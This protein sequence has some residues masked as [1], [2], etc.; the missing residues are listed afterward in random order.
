MKMYYVLILLK[1]EIVKLRIKMASN[2][3]VSVK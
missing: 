2:H 1:Q 3:K